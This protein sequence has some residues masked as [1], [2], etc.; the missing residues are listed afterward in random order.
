MLTWKRLW[1]M[2][3]HGD[4][5]RR[6]S[7]IIHTITSSHQLTVSFRRHPIISRL[8]HTSYPLMAGHNKWSKIKRPKAAADFERSVQ[9][10]KIC[11]EIRAAVRLGGDDPNTNLR[12][13]GVIS[14]A[15]SS[16]IPKSTIENAIASAMA[17]QQAHHGGSVPLVL[18]EA[19]SSGYSI[20]IEVNNAKRTKNELQRILKVYKSV[21]Y[22]SICV[23][24]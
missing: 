13:A 15:R 21:T 23:L 16:D 14:R 20:L 19:R 3:K 12:L 2:Y 9:I 7:L 24:Y 17:Q 11:T 5:L 4:T 8:Y 1:H 18:Y 22:T 10:G 6:C